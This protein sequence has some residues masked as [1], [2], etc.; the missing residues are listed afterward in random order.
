M[1][2]EEDG[3]KAQVDFKHGGGRRTELLDMIGCIETGLG[4]NP[5]PPAVRVMGT[6]WARDGPSS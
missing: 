4:S 5:A 6:S 2:K 1:L 3:Y